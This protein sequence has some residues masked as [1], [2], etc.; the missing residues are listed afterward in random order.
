MLKKLFAIILV[1]ILAGG[2]Y[3]YVAGTDPPPPPGEEDGF[4]EIEGKVFAGQITVIGAT[5][6]CGSGAISDI[7]DNDGYYYLKFPVGTVCHTNLGLSVPPYQ[8]AA[9]HD[10]FGMAFV[11]V[12]ALDNQLVWQ[13]I[14]FETGEGGDDPLDGIVR[15]YVRVVDLCDDYLGLPARLDPEAW[16]RAGWVNGILGEDGWYKLEAGYTGATNL[17]ISAG[18]PGHIQDERVVG[19]ISDTQKL[20]Y[21]FKLWEIGQTSCGGS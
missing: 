3:Y 13:D 20:F 10:N 7:T 14:G 5:V 4:I 18:A 8:I 6:T 9:Q 1:L 2:L 16:V 21:T 12:Q 19:P 11:Q 15:V 17:F